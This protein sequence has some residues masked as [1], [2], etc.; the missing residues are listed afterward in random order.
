LPG[1]SV[2]ACADGG[3]AW[4]IGA[5]V[6][7]AQPAP[8]EPSQFMPVS[9]APLHARA[10]YSRRMGIAFA[11]SANYSAFSHAPVHAPLRKSPMRRCSYT[12][13]GSARRGEG[14][15]WEGIDQYDL[16]PQARPRRAPGH[17]PAPSRSYMSAKVLPGIRPAPYRSKR[18]GLRS[19][20]NFPNSQTLR[21]GSQTVHSSTSRSGSQM[22]SEAPF[23]GLVNAN[24]PGCAAAEKTLRAPL[25]RS[26]TRV[27]RRGRFTG[28]SAAPARWLAAA[29]GGALRRAGSDPATISLK[30]LREQTFTSA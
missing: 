16:Q 12:R 1:F 18:G 10:K 30:H 8:H 23:A 25:Q 26:Q 7:H 17:A 20:P 28:V 6:A 19:A 3:G 29:P 5:W 4:A 15:L 14:G 27:V 2:F 11:E 22:A 21:S 9:H 24:D 13:R